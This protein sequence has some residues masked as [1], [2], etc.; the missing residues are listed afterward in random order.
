MSDITK[1]DTKDCPLE[2]TCYR[3]IAPSSERQS[4]ANLEHYLDRQRIICS[5]YR[6]R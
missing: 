6:E 5:M 2:K 1:C 3:K 4:Y